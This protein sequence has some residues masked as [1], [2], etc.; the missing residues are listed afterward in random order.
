VGCKKKPVEEEEDL[1]ILSWRYASN[2]EQ[3]N[4]HSIHRITSTTKSVMT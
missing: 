3:L 4:A 1:M 2:E